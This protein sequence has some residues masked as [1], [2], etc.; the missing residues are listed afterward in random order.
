MHFEK[1]GLSSIFCYTHSCILKYSH[2]SKGMAYLKFK[3]FVHKYLAARN[4]A[5]TDINKIKII[6]YS[7]R[8]IVDKNCYFYVKTLKLP[9]Q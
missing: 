9:C 8:R 3:G 4:I 5:L 6:N 7:L 2:I 1:F